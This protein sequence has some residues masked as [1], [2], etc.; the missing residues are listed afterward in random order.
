MNWI[1]CRVRLAFQR[2]G[3][4]TALKELQ[5]RRRSIPRTLLWHVRITFQRPGIRVPCGMRTGQEVRVRPLGKL[6][7]RGHGATRAWPWFLGFSEA[8]PGFYA[9][10]FISA[11]ALDPSRF[12]KRPVIMMD[13]PYRRRSKAQ[14]NGEM[15]QENGEKKKKKI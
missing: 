10:V 3:S 15:L 14:Q 6:R 9:P 2:T 5:S 8:V 4:R 7:E 11:P 13:A 12:S 1:S